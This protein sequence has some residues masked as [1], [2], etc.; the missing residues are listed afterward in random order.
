LSEDSGDAVAI[1][2]PWASV[3]GAD[4]MTQRMTEFMKKAPK[5]TDQKSMRIKPNM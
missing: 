4:R 1:S 5:E 2:Y 3:E